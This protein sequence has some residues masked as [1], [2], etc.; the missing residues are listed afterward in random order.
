MATYKAPSYDDKYR[1]GVDTSFF[2]NAVN[3]YTQQANKERANQIG[4][5][6][7]ERQSN[8]RQAYVNRL[9]NEQSL[10]NNLAMSGIR[11]GATETSNLRLA[12]TY[13]QARASAN[14]NYANSVNSINRSTDQNIAD[15]TS[16]MNSRAEEYIQNMAQAKWQADREDYATQWNATREDELRK[17]EWAREDANLKYDR[18]IAEQN[19][20]AEY[21]NNYYI[22]KYS[23]YSKDQL[24]KA[25]EK[26]K[27]YLKSAEKRND[28]FAIIRWQQALSGIGA[29]RGVIATS[30]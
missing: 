27:G 26:V 20:R 24:K 5:A 2:T 19:R 11:G 14:A 6:Q 3:T 29:R 1:Q 8:L 17:K 9:Q 28:T 30:K 13:G 16:D 25:E 23:G 4:D 7:R 18:Q 12:N 10:N 21:W 22:S 15:Y